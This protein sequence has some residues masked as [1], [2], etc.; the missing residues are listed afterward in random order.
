MLKIYTQSVSCDGTTY[1]ALASD[2]PF[3]SVSMAY[4]TR[5]AIYSS[6]DNASTGT[7]TLKAHNDNIVYF[8]AGS[9]NTRGGDFYHW[10]YNVYDSKRP[11][12]VTATGLSIGNTYFV[13]V[14]SDPGNIYIA[15]NAAPANDACLTALTMLQDVTYPVDNTSS[16]LWSDLNVPDAAYYI[17]GSES[18]ENVLYFAFTP[19]ATATYY[20]N[21]WSAVCDLGIGTQ[22]VIW[23][24]GTTCATMPT[25]TSGL[26]TALQYYESPTT[27]ADRYFSKA[28]TMGVKY[29][30]II[31]GG[32]GD[33]CTFN[34]RI[35]KDFPLPIELLNFYSKCDNNET[36]IH[37]STASEIN[38]NFFSVERSSD[39]KIFTE[40]ATVAGAENSSSTL[41]YSYNDNDPLAGK[42]FYRIT[43]TDYNGESQ[44]FAPVSVNCSGEVD[45]DFTVISLI[46][47]GEIQMSVANTDG[48]NIHIVLTDIFGRQVYSRA[49]TNESDNYLLTLSPDHK[50]NP[51]VYFLTASSS[52]KQITKKIVVE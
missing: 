29:Y 15:T 4:D 19:T 14:D 16:T 21:Q 51:G 11:A 2:N 34:L 5:I 26:N 20:V 35:T 44:T 27:T 45:F 3:S 23:T 24:G 22:F 28:M 52:D 46:T 12:A 39:G 37:W 43:Q 9:P 25:M 6:S 30:I 42:S 13:R 7:F 32:Q 36:V 50:L 48:N 18:M 33:E 17:N 38:N 41:N 40:I 1:S 47:N 49:V 8:G 10:W 31:D